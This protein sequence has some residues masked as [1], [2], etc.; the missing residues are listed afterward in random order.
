MIQK[1]DAK[2]EVYEAI[3]QL[4]EEHFNQKNFLQ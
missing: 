2:A 1:T 4:D 3:M